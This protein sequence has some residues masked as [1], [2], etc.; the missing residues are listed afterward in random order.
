MTAFADFL[1]LRTA[2]IEMVGRPD[3]ADVMP[4]LTLLAESHLNRKLRTNDQIASATV[5]FDGA[6]AVAPGDFLSAISLHDVNGCEYF[7]QGAA[8][9]AKTNKCYSVAGRELISKGLSGDLTLLYYGRI[10]TITGIYNPLD[11]TVP[12]GAVYTYTPGVAVASDSTDIRAGDV[13]GSNWLLEAYPE[14]YLYSVGLEAARYVR[15]PEAANYI[16]ALRDEAL[17]EIRAND[18]RARYSRARVALPGV[19]P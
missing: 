14:A 9:T 6:R 11:P 7:Q 1:D 15:D 2:V 3:I 5:T 16:Q 18:N 17:S 4:R 19:T 8:I 13:T 10:P 12:S